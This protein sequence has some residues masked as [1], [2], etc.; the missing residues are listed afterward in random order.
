MEI[1][2]PQS[3][4]VDTLNFY[5]ILDCPG[6][7]PDDDKIFTYIKSKIKKLEFP[8]IVLI[9]ENSWNDYGY[10]THF[11]SV[12]IHN[13]SEIKTL[14]TVKIIQSKAKD[15]S[16]VLPTKFLELPKKE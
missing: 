11:Y 4:K 5:S 10:F 14:G 13:S 15:N 9:K 16:T 1:E 3:K 2:I 6:R 7:L 8:C 12:F